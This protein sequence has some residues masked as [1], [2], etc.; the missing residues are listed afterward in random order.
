V[1]PVFEL[2]EQPINGPVV[3]PQYKDDHFGQYLV[4]DHLKTSPIFRL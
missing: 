3:R 4:L 2:S 1:R